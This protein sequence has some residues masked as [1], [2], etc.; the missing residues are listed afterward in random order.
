M[1]KWRNTI[2]GGAVCFT[3]RVEPDY[4][5]TTAPPCEGR[6]KDIQLSYNVSVKRTEISVPYVGVAYRL[7]SKVGFLHGTSNIGGFLAVFESQRTSSLFI[8]I[9]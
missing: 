9:R 5:H 7:I 3:A 2:G 6:K 8:S 1:G 4:R